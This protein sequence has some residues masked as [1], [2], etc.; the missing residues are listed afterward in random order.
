MVLLI[1]TTNE[2]IG[3]RIASE[4]ENSNRGK[5]YEYVDASDMNITHCLGCNFCWLKTPGQCVMKDG[6]EQLLKKMSK[7]D[8]VWLISDTKFG[9]VSH[10]TKNIVDRVMPLVTMNLHIVGKQ[11]RHIMRYDKN[12]DWG[13]I[14]AGDGDYEYLDW[15]CE[16]VAVNF[17]SKSLGVFSENEYREAIACM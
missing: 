4:L 1:D 11:M 12:P 15:W 3:Q 8:Q 16:R 6:Y 14:Y 13:V 9:F 7:S 17:G 5:T 2:R 10:K